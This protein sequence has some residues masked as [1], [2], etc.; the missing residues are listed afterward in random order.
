MEGVV[1]K[2]QKFGFCKYK[3]SCEKKN[4]LRR[5]VK[6]FHLVIAKETVTKDT[7]MHAKGMFWKA[8]A[9]LVLTVPIIT[10]H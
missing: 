7:P 4:I 10:R 9:S 2:F 3:E 5:R 8:S 6:N 1:C